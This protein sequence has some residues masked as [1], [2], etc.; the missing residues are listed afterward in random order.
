MEEA[1]VEEHWLDALSR[2]IISPVPRRAALRSAATFTAGL[3]GPSLSAAS[4]KKNKNKKTKKTAKNGNRKRKP[5]PKVTP[6]SCG[7][8][9]CAEFAS[10][11]DRDYCE[12]ICRQCDEADPRKFCI[13]EGDPFNPAKVAICCVEGATCCHGQCCSSDHGFPGNRCCPGVG[14]VDTSNDSQHCGQCSNACLSGQ[15]CIDGGCLPDRPCPA[16]TVPCGGP[17]VRQPEDCCEVAACFGC[18]V[19]P[20]PS[21]PGTSLEQCVY[22]CVDEEVCVDG[23]CCLPAGTGCNPG[24]VGR[25]FCCSGLMCERDEASGGNRCQ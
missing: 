12:F 22:R 3:L 8:G 17:T 13:V 5:K 24:N 6:T 2:K 9:A 4:A 23:G 15:S 25:G 21:N 18:A 16:Q 19:A 11:G 20:D 14:C 7:A 10:Q 1:M